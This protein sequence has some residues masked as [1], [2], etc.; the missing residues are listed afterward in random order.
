MRKIKAASGKP[1]YWV[2][3]PIL[4]GLAADRLLPAGEAFRSSEGG[5]EIGR[6]ELPSLEEIVGRVAEK[7]HF[8]FEFVDGNSQNVVDTPDIFNGTNAYRCWDVTDSMY[9]G[10]SS[11]VVGNSKYVFG[12]YLRILA[13]EFCINCYDVTDIRGSL[14]IESCHNCSGL[15]FSHNCENVQDGIFCFNAKGLRHAIGNTEVPRDEYARVKRI[16]L[17]YVNSELEGKGRLDF[18]IFTVGALG[19]PKTRN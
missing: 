9:A 12:G 1:T 5:I 17:D 15:Y 18:D 4:R 11:G 19:N 8:T 6:G 14:E 7:A 16:L 3:L 10:Y 2:N 13:S